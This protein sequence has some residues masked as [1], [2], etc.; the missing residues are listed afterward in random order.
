MKYSDYTV[1]D[2]VADECFE[3]W[4]NRPDPEV[5]AFWEAWLAAYPE[6]EESIEEA[7]NVI[8]MLKFNASKY[9][10]YEAQHL[11]DK[12]SAT[13]AKKEI[14]DKKD[15]QQKNVSYRRFIQVWSQVAA[16]TG[17]LLLSIIAYIM[18]T[19]HPALEYTTE[20]GEKKVI[21][22]PDSSRVIL[23]ANSA[24]SYHPDWSE[25]ALREVYLEGEAFFEVRKQPY[26]GN[27]KFVVHTDKLDVEVMGTQ[28]N[29]S[30]R[31]GTT[32]VT[33]N[34]GTVQLNSD[35]AKLVKN[36]LM[37]PGEQAELT[38]ENIFEIRKVNTDLYTS[39]KDNK[40]IFEN[41]TI[42]EISQIIE[43]NYGL[44]MVVLDT[45]IFQRKFTGTLPGNNLDIILKTFS[46]LYQLD[47]ERDKGQIFLKKSDG[48]GPGG[49]PRPSPSGRIKMSAP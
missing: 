41:A 25:D 11:L 47:I 38:S 27:K 35:I 33:L 46:E 15:Q 20:F 13:I 23:N 30:E 18:L 43:D 32:T 17:L 7:R 5:N 1:A 14:S 34:E 26:T 22:L 45:A 16:V 8:R 36:I 10:R 21:L 37:Q 9:S 39:W 44:G 28:F 48:S 2:F 24:L 40:L 19:A 42:H 29:V 12:I 31:E 6:K 49:E 4:V 3:K